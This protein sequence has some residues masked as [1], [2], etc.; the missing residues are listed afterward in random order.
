MGL[1]HEPAR[2]IGTEIED[3]EID[4]EFPADLAE[5]VKVGGVSRNIDRVSCGCFDEIRSPQSGIG[6][7]NGVA[8]CPMVARQEHDLAGIIS[9]RSEPVELGDVPGPDIF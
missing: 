3:G 7:D 1:F 9:V 4:I 6:T 8:H 5:P 2:L